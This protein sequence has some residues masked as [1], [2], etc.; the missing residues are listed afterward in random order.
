MTFPDAEHMPVFPPK[1]MQR[2]G[3]EV[4]DGWKCD[5]FG[6]RVVRMGVEVGWGMEE[7]LCLP[8]SR[9]FESGCF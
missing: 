6:G 8:S 1:E 2:V 7:M 5:N 9:T 3:H 4:C